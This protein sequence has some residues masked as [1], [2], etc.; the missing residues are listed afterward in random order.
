MVGR[1]CKLPCKA[2]NLF[3]WNSSLRRLQMLWNK[4]AGVLFIKQR[5]QK[6]D[7]RLEVGMLTAIV[8]TF[9]RNS[10]WKWKEVKH[11]Q[12]LERSRH[13]RR[14]QKSQLPKVH[15]RILPRFGEQV[16]RMKHNERG[17]GMK[18]GK[19]EALAH[20]RETMG[21]VG[22]RNL[23]RY[24]DD[25]AISGANKNKLWISLLYFFIWS[26]NSTCGLLRISADFLGQLSQD[27]HAQRLLTG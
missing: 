15:L 8:H 3:G 4:K 16:P 24:S 23:D 13:Y 27:N 9:L 20:I 19:M 6:Q 7:D 12:S 1:W 14:L 11:H 18:H 26:C 22:T 2:S 25:Q 5:R 10:A 17:I 21:L